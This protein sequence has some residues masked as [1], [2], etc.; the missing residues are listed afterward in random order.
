[1]A[2]LPKA[3]Q[4]CLEFD[5]FCKRSQLPPY[6]CALL[7]QA[8]RLAFAEGERVANGETTTR[9]KADQFEAYAE[10]S[11]LRVEWYGL[12]PTLYDRYGAE[13]RLPC[14]D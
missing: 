8:A 14:F 4:F 12:W 10:Q 11:N 9:P 2:K 5:Y 3:L 13:L 7:I 6:Q 1:M